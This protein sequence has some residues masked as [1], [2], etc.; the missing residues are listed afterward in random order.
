MGTPMEELA[1]GLKELKGF[2]APLFFSLI[3]YLPSSKLERSNV[4]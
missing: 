2:A 4:D 1:E 3:L